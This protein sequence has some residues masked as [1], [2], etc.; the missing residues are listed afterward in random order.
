MKSVV[1]DEND[2][3]CL[4]CGR[5]QNLEKHHMVHGIGKRKVADKLGLWCYLCHDCH[6]EVHVNRELDMSLIQYAQK[7]YEKDHTRADFR[8]AFG[9]SYL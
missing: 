9:K 5:T 7:C 1:I 4:L 6:Q 2:K 8:L 3:A